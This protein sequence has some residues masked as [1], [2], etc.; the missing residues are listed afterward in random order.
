MITGI[1]PFNKIPTKKKTGNPEIETYSNLRV[2][3]FS[4]LASYTIIITPRFYFRLGLLPHFCVASFDTEKCKHAGG[5]F[6]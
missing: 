6:Y 3:F 2:V 1:A 5:E 4:F